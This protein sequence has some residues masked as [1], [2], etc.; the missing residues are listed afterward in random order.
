MKNFHTADICDARPDAKIID[1]AFRDYGRRRIFHGPVTTIKAFE[2]NS[3]VHA[4]LEE[5]GNGRVLVVDGGGSLNRSM[6][7]GQLAAKAALNNWSGIVVL[8]AVRDIH[9]IAMIDIAVKALGTCPQKTN[10]QGQG[11][12]DVTVKVGSIP[13]HPG[14]YLYADEDGIVI[15]DKPI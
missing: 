8:A 2:D 14:D 5:K 9:E 1:I 3:L 15:L 12:R 10:K 6:L 7:G 13:V 4:A 11:T